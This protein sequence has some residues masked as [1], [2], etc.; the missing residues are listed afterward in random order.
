MHSRSD[1]IPPAPLPTPDPNP[2]PPQ[3]HN[4]RRRFQSLDPEDP[5]LQW[6]WGEALLATDRAGRRMQEAAVHLEVAAAILSR[7]HERIADAEDGP[8]ASPGALEPVGGA[9]DG[10]AEGGGAG[11]GKQQRL[12]AAGRAEGL[13]GRKLDAVE[14]L[15]AAAGPLQR[16]VE[17]LTAME[18][19]GGRG[20]EGGPAALRHVRC[21]ALLRLC[22]LRLRRA[23]Y[24]RR[25]GEAPGRAAVLD[26]RAE[27]RR[28]VEGMRGGGCGAQASQLA[29]LIG[30]E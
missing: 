12:S 11:G 5:W 6:E 29:K 18:A 25:R 1:P 10:G 8:A 7:L 3:T 23:L 24:P 9:D 28:C 22:H 16:L 13:D 15:G 2:P 21:E 30:Q 17:V 14:A 19:A 20:W 26:A 27:G 4:R